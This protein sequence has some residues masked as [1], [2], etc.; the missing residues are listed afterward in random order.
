MR[1]S[2]E[3]DPQPGSMDHTV[4]SRL[5]EAIFVDTCWDEV[6][7]DY[8]GHTLCLS[9]FDCEGNSGRGTAAWNEDIDKFLAKL[10][11]GN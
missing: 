2:F 1:K 8:K 3:D 5:P 10:A 11:K 4:F 9:V 7:Y 6:R